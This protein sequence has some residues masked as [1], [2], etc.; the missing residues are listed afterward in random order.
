MITLAINIAAFLFLAYVVIGG[1]AFIANIIDIAIQSR[2]D[3]KM[4]T[5][6]KG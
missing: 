2:A 6:F 1:L 3:K 5:N 4:Y